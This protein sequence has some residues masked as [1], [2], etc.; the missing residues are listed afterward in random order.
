MKIQFDDMT[1]EFSDKPLTEK[2]RKKLGPKLSKM[3]E[4]LQEIAKEDNDLINEFE[5]FNKGQF[6]KD[7]CIKK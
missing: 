6:I 2:D 5:S 7:F 1:L 3:F 4:A